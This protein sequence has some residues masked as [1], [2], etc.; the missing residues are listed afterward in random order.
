MTCGCRQRI[1]APRTRRACNGRKNKHL[2]LVSDVDSVHELTRMFLPFWQHESTKAS[3]SDERMNC[4]TAWARLHGRSDDLEIESIRNFC[5]TLLSRYP[6]STCAAA[7]Y[8][9]RPSTGT[10]CARKLC[11]ASSSLCAPYSTPPSCVKE[12]EELC[13]CAVPPTRS[14][15]AKNHTLA[16]KK[17]KRYAKPDT[18][19]T[20]AKPSVAAVAAVAEAR[21][22]NDTVRAAAAVTLHIARSADITIDLKS[23]K[24]NYELTDGSILESSTLNNIHK[25]L[26]RAQLPATPMLHIHFRMVIAYCKQGRRRAQ[27]CSSSSCSSY[28]TSTIG[29][30]IITLRHVL[31]LSANSSCAK[32]FIILQRVWICFF[33]K[34]RGY[35]MSRRAN[36]LKEASSFFA[37]LHL[38]VHITYIRMYTCPCTPTIARKNISGWYKRSENV[39]RKKTSQQQQRRACIDWALPVYKYVAKYDSKMRAAH[40]VSVNLQRDRCA[41]RLSAI[42]VVRLESR[43]S[44]ALEDRT[45][46]DLS[47]VYDLQNLR[48]AR[49]TNWA[50]CRSRSVV[51]VA[52]H[53]LFTSSIRIK[54]VIAQSHSAALRVYV[55]KT[56]LVEHSRSA[57]IFTSTN[58]HGHNISASRSAAA[59]MVPYGLFY[60]LWQK[61]SYVKCSPTFPWTIVIFDIHIVLFAIPFLSCLLESCMLLSFCKVHVKPLKPFIR[62]SMKRKVFQK[63]RRKSL[64]AYEEDIE[65]RRDRLRELLLR[66]EAEQTRELVDLFRLKEKQRIAEL[67]EKAAAEE[68]EREQARQAL[69]KEKKLQRYVESSQERR[70]SNVTKL[71]SVKSNQASIKRLVDERCWLTCKIYSVKINNSVKLRIT[72]TPQLVRFKVQ[73]STRYRREGA[74]STTACTCEIARLRCWRE[75]QNCVIEREISGVYVRP[76]LEVRTANCKQ[77]NYTLAPAKVKLYIKALSSSVANG[78]ELLLILK[79][80]YNILISEAVPHVQL[81]DAIY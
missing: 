7:Q 62:I 64:E 19:S 71:A 38:G 78:A 23:T 54:L 26:L 13:L 53:E 34:T 20:E 61:V 58:Q 29:S 25:T 81:G 15:R 72:R 50:N 76:R 27:L 14:I 8:T 44:L 43:E 1:A 60:I 66:E 18:K 63:T 74:T 4:R 46:T 10:K 32:A 42:S 28:Y 2:S 31:V 59:R 6:W 36:I 49:C 57:G 12:F 16:N 35:S 45:A 33:G 73:L 69:L 80:L 75:R 24:T 47:C 37:R 30:Y 56:R 22:G 55:S 48:L 65:E 67:A 52:L 3:L 21:C 41:S 51:R 77:Q 9:T 17:S 70:C 79:S 5:K 39:D 11:H 68:R 40:N